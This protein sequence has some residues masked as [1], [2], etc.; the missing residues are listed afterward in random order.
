MVLVGLARSASENI[1]GDVYIGGAN[2][3][4]ETTAP[5]DLFAAGFSVSIEGE[6]TGDAHLAGF[7][8]ETDGPIGGDLYAVGSNISVDG[9]VRGDLTASGFSIRIKSDAP[10]SGNGRVAGGTVK[11]DAPISGS[12]VVVGGN[13][14]LNGSID[15]DVRVTTAKLTFGETARIGGKLIYST[16]ESVEVPESVAPADRVRYEKLERPG[17]FRDMRDTIGDSIPG[18]W[19]SFL[20]VFGLFVLTLAFLL[21]LA[22]VFLT[23]APNPTSRLQRQAAERPGLALLTGFFGLAL[24]LGL[25]PVSGMTLIGIPFIPI[26]LLGIVVLWVLG[27]LLGIYWLAMAIWSAFGR[28][29]AST[30]VRLLVLAA[31]LVVLAVLNF[32]P[33]LG[34]LINLAVVLS[35]LGAIA[36]MLLKR[37]CSALVAMDEEAVP[38]ESSGGT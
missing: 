7:D 14:E 35:G 22:A 26:V 6:T 10:I 31:G 18:F 37:V 1:G 5:R 11:I 29:A 20:T 9:A 2:P 21:V 27:Y 34:W 13:V 15:G 38:A 19:P 30:G 16:P 32:I 28:E 33:F 12:L 36:L 24:V 17:A 8:V 3:S 4:L 25:V 23:F